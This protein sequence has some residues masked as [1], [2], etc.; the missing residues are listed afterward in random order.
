M[1]LAHDED[2]TV[3]K[4]DQVLGPLQ[5]DLSS[6]QIKGRHIEEVKDL[7]PMGKINDIVLHD[8][9]TGLDKQQEEILDSVLT[10]VLG[11]VNQEGLLDVKNNIL[12]SIKGGADAWKGIDKG[13]RKEFLNI[14]SVVPNLV[15]RTRRKVHRDTTRKV[16]SEIVE[17]MKYV[18]MMYL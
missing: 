2:Y 7:T 15:T 10:K 13:T 17:T 11:G 4:S 18:N 12:P 6:W 3:V 8:L 14:F 9:V 5:H 1:M 16:Y